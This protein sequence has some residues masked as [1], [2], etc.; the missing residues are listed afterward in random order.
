MKNSSFL[1]IPNKIFACKLKPAAFK[2]YIYLSCVIYCKENIQVKLATI[3]KRCNIGINTAGRAI[4]SLIAKGLIRKIECYT[5]HARTINT[6]IVPKLGGNFSM[7][8]AKYFEMKALK[9]SSFLL[10]SYLNMRS[11]SSKKSFPSLNTIIGDTGLCK[12]TVLKHSRALSGGFH[13]YKESYLTD[14]GKFGNNNYTLL[15]LKQR[16]LFCWI[17]LRY[18]V[19]VQAARHSCPRSAK[20]LPIIM[21]AIMAFF[22]AFYG[23]LIKIKKTFI[24]FSSA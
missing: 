4:N 22:S 20:I 14:C 6:Y 16:L 8:S 10:F 12:N 19:C 15:S 23:L 1:K 7:L 11:N 5:D 18:K 13:L 24:G 17:L 2:V 21:V 9:N 3:A